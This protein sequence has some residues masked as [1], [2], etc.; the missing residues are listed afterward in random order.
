MAA[1]ALVRDAMVAWLRGSQHGCT[2]ASK[3][4]LEP[5]GKIRPLIINGTATSS[6]LAEQLQP[7]LLDAGEN[8][9]AVLVVFPDFR[10]DEH[11]AEL[12]NT[13]ANSD[14]WVCVE[15]DWKN[16]PRDAL[17]VRL[18]WSAG[19]IR[20]IAM[21]LGPLPTMPLTR[22]SPFVA[23]AVWPGGKDNEFNPYRNRN[24]DRVSLAD[25]P[26]ALDRETH[27]AYWAASENK[28]RQIAE[29]LKEDAARP[30]VTFCLR[31]DV[32]RLI[33]SLAAG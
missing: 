28:K 12:V 21:G 24:Q 32:R 9:E 31:S 15:A 14:W 5:S 33:S 16:Y 13:L 11:V 3:F 2:F 27:D 25:M 20:S 18:E 7:H 8:K 1:D 10:L 22:R 19:G 17:L 30:V 26:H 23:I 6:H 29:A 4:A